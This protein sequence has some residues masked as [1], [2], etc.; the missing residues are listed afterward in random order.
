MEALIPIVALGGLAMSIK[1]D[2]KPNTNSHSK[3]KGKSITENYQNMNS[4]NQALKNSVSSYPNNTTNIQHIKN[5][6]VNPNDATAKYFDQNS[7]YEAD[8][9]GKEPGNNIHQFHSLTGSYV[10]STDFQHNNM[11]TYLFRL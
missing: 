7:Y 5:A 8:I 10:S 1:N 9:R 2:P 3:M 4:S 11:T 6:Y